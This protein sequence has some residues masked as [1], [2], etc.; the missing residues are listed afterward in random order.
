VVQFK[1]V[2]VAACILRVEH[3]AQLVEHLIIDLSFAIS[4]LQLQLLIVLR[5]REIDIFQWDIAKHVIV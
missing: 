5:L 2:K 3:Y 4:A 1:R